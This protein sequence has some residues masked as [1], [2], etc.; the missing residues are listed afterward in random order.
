MKDDEPQS[1][2]PDVPDSLPGC[3]G[4]EEPLFPNKCECCNHADVCKE[5]RK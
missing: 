4:L 3:L 2:L 5:M 1:D